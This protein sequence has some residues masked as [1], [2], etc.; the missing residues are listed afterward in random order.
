MIGE[1]PDSDPWSAWHGRGALRVSQPDF[2]VIGIHVFNAGDGFK[3][4]DA[5]GGAAQHFVLE[6]SW[7]QHVH[8]DC[9]ENDYLHSGVIRDDLLDGC[10]VMF[11]ARPWATGPD[12]QHNVLVIDRVVGSLEPMQLGLSRAESRDG[13][14]LQMVQP[15]AGRGPDEQRLHGEPA[16]QPRDTRA[17]DGP[18]GVQGNAIVWAGKRPVP[19]CRGVA[20]SRCPDTVITTDASR[21]TG[22]EA[23]WLASHPAVG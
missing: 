23:A 20:G 18:A 3:A 12:G 22:S 10:Y 8:D 15:G 14:L 13:R 2:T 17:P 16:S 4:K 21:Y 7:I 5:S 6:G 9:I 1:W 19:G 11:S